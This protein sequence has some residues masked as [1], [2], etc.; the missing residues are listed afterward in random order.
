MGIMTSIEKETEQAAVRAAMSLGA[1]IKIGAI[2]VLIIAIIVLGWLYR[3]EIQSAA[4]LAQQVLQQQ[5]IIDDQSRQMAEAIKKSRENEA[6]AAD[7]QA[8]LRKLQHQAEGL[9]HEIAKIKQTDPQVKE[10]SE[11]CMPVA[12]YD[13]LPDD[14]RVRIPAGGHTH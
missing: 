6:I 8:R 1:K 3:R 11:S 14:M 5:T 7:R 4:G 9:R 10:W 13:R 2:V 12:L